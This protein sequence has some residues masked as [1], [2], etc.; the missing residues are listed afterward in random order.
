MVYVSHDLAVV[1]K[2]ADRIVVMYAGRVVEH[3]PAD[4][5]IERPR[6]PYTRA[7]VAAI[8]DFRRPRALQRHPRR[9]GRR[10]R[11]ARRLR[12]R[13]ALRAQRRTA[14]TAGV[15]VLEARRRGH[16]VRCCRWQEL[17][18]ARRRARRARARRGGA[19]AGA[20]LLEVADLEVAV[21]HRPHRPRRP[22]TTSRSRSSRAAASRWSASP[23]AARPRS[24][25][26]SPGCTSR[27]AGTD[28]FDGAELAGAA[29]RARRSTQRRRIQIVFQN[30]FESLNPRH[31]VGS[32]IERPLRVL[33]GCRGPTPTARSASCST[34]CG[35]RGALARPLPDRAL[36]RRAPARRDRPGAGRAS[37]TC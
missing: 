19:S 14:A 13:A 24:A 33:R 17:A 23:A 34:G 10:R 35:C 2:M 9:L 26:A 32:S 11:V 8:P 31:R 18:A 22:C 20:P 37:P 16:A 36:R 28:R 27:A 29:R 30:P 1:A 5:V 15:P 4:E 21:P 3:G 25:A 12:V 6:H 7:L